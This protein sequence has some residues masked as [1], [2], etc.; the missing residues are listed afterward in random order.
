MTTPLKTGILGAGRI[1]SSFGSPD[2]ELP[3]SLAHAIT[4]TEGLELA[5]FFD[6]C[7]QS[8]TAAEQKWNC[9]PSPRDLDTWLSQEWDV[10]CIANPDDQH[11]PTL[12]RIFTHSSQPSAILAEKPLCTDVTQAEQLLTSA[13]TQNIPLQVNFPRRWHPELQKL[14]QRIHSGEWGHLRRLQVT[15]SGG[16]FHN[17]SH[18]IDLLASWL[19]H[20]F[21]AEHSYQLLSPNSGTLGGA[22]GSPPI[23]IVLH[24]AVQD[25]CYVWDVI[26]DFDQ[27]RITLS[28]V[29]ETLTVAVRQPHPDFE[30]FHALLT[31]SQTNLEKA[32]LMLYSAANLAQIARDPALAQNQLT[33]E[34]LHHQLLASIFTAHSH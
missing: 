21:L 31:E 29:P 20:E 4:L 3:L 17:G 1:A 9:P 24:E 33:L 14:A 30:G 22:S 28:G 11:A 32:P 6:V 34:K 8:A 15:C 13:A 5:G 2:D 23:E 18:A 25:D 12:E 27:A 7:E 16:L 10:I 19:P 26:A